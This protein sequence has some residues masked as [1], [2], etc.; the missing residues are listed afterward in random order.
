MVVGREVVDRPRTSRSKRVTEAFADATGR[1]D[2][3]LRWA[4]TVAAA[5]GG[6]IGVLR[7]LDRLEDLGVVVLGHPRKG[8]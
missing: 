6:L 7:L 3:Q 1:T 4:L 5:E 2:E 8:P